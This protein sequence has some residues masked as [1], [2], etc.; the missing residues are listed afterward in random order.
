AA[1]ER[2]ARARDVP[3]DLTGLLR[4]RAERAQQGLAQDGRAPAGRGRPGDAGGRWTR[5]DHTEPDRV[6]RS[7][8]R[9]PAGFGRDDSDRA[10]NAP[11]RADRLSLATALSACGRAP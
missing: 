9:R 4:L 1:D 6:R 5:G 8:W 2:L 11:G 3:T 10:R 7:G